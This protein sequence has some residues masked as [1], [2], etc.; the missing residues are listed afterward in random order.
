MVYQRC[1]WPAHQRDRL[2]NA[3]GI[4][5]GQ[6]VDEPGGGIC[7]V[8][9]TLYIALIKSEVE[10]VT[11]SHHS[12]P[13]S[14]VPTGLDATIST[15]GPDFVYRNNYDTPIA[16]VV[17]VDGKDERS[18]TVKVHGPKRLRCPL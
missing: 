17:T 16:V 18:I 15:G 6:Y 9:S 3:A 11:R 12:W 1:G 7:Q 8:S 10:I 5:D 13:L 4:S 2:E 14:Y